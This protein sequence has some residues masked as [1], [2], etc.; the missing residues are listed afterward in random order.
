MVPRQPQYPCNY[1]AVRPRQMCNVYTVTHSLNP[2]SMLLQ[3]HCNI[4]PLGLQLSSSRTATPFQSHCNTLPIGLQP[5]SSRTAVFLQWDCNIPPVG[6]QSS[7]SRAA[8]LLQ[9]HCSLPSVG[10]QSTSSRAA[11]LL[12]SHCNPHG[13]PVLVF[14]GLFC[15]F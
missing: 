2:C 3:S 10:L 7:S 13:L 4:T 15:F 14:F 1:T 11:T 8:A 12:Q 9:S 6:L 5:F